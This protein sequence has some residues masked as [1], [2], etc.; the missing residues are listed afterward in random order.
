M[1][2]TSN[3]LKSSRAVL[4]TFIS[5]LSGFIHFKQQCNMCLMLDIL[6][7]HIKSEISV[8]EYL[9]YIVSYFK[10]KFRL[11]GECTVE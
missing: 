4:C 2:D 10:D 7:P 11:A 9:L 8:S 3:V 6:Y 1:L 5:H